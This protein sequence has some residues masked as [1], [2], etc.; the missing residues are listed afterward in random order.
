MIKIL[1]TE[2]DKKL[3]FD[4]RLKVFVDEQKVPLELEIDEKDTLATTVHIGCFKD[5]KLVGV[6]RLIDMDKEII[7]IGR[8]AID[9]NY[10]GSGLGSE[11]MLGCE[12]VAKEVLKH[13]FTLELSAQVQA[14]NFYKNLGYSRVNNNIYLDAG[15]KHVDM[16]KTIS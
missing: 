7:H 11:I 16:K 4:L 14:E 6:A 15:I 12:E 1:N 10:R 3:G 2:A 13:P 8:V 5:E 9:K